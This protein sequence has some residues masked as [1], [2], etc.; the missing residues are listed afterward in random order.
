MDEEAHC[1]TEATKTAAAKP[2]GRSEAALPGAQG[3]LHSEAF[4]EPSKVGRA[5]SDCAVIPA[6]PEGND[7]AGL[8]PNPC[9]Q[10]A[11]VVLV[12]GWLHLRAFP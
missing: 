2:D 10:W 3:C 7:T 6:L 5:L 1:V 8:G 4:A 9:G 11:A 12:Q